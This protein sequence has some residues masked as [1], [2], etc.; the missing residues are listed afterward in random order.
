MSSASSVPARIQRVTQPVRHYRREHLHGGFNQVNA[1]CLGSRL[2][3][4]A[5]INGLSLST[6]WGWTYPQ[7]G[8]TVPWLPR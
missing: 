5:I 4:S 3:G 1:G 6:G 2:M 7:L 8:G